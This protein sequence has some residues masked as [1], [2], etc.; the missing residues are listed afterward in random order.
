MWVKAAAGSLGN[1]CAGF[2][3]VAL[4]FN[5]FLENQDD[6]LGVVLLPQSLDNGT[7]D[8]NCAKAKTA[9]TTSATTATTS[10]ATTEA[11][12]LHSRLH[13]PTTT[14]TETTSL[15][16]QS[17]FQTAVLISVSSDRS[18][19]RRKMGWCRYDWFD[20]NPSL[21]S[22]YVCALCFYLCPVWSPPNIYLRISLS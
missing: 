13:S 1:D 5:V 18:A 14:Q 6:S 22:V 10:S 19:N 3:C 8:T 16:S 15:S 4:G 17:Q 7:V 21:I 20:S 11:P 2:F 9:T 12:A